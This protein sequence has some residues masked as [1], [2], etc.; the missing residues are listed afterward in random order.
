MGTN[1][2]YVCL[3]VCL[4][5]RGV[6]AS[7]RWR[8]DVRTAGAPHTAWRFCNLYGTCTA[9]NAHGSLTQD[10]HL[11]MQGRVCN[12]VNR[13]HFTDSIMN[14]DS[15]D[16]RFSGGGSLTVRSILVLWLGLTFVSPGSLAGPPCTCY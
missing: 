14:C 1:Q 7:G 8:E 16:G 6:G 15:V 2:V 12:S 3:C 9:S 10:F 13:E 5:V 11:V 4:Q